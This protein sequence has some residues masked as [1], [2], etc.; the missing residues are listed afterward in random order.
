M[1]VDFKYR[2]FRFILYGKYK[3]KAQQ[4]IGNSFPFSHNANDIAI[5]ELFKN[6]IFDII[7]ARRAYKLPD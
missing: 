3:K 5:F 6:L 2:L 1:P 4:S 7:P